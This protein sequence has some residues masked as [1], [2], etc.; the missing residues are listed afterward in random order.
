ME[1]WSTDI[2]LQFNQLR[3]IS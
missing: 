1:L 2:Y 3:E